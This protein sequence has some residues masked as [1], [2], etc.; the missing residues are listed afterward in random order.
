MGEQMSDPSARKVNQTASRGIV[1]ILLLAAGLRI[2]GIWQSYP[3]S[4]Y[5]DEVH[6]VERALSFGSFDFNPHWFHK[7]AFFMYLLSV[8]YGIYF[9]VGKIAGAWQS[10]SGFAT[11]YILNPGPFF[12]LGRGLTAVFSLAT[13][14]M[15]YKLARKHFDYEVGLLSALLLTLSY[16]HVVSSQHVKADSPTTF[17]TVASMYFLLNFLTTRLDRDVLVASAIAGMGA[18]TKYYSLI[19]LAPIWI[20][21]AVVVMGDTDS[22]LRRLRRFTP[23]VVAATLS[24]WLAYFV[25]SPFNFLDPLGR[26]T[27]F[28]W[29]RRLSRSFNRVVEGGGGEGAGKGGGGLF[30]WLAESV[31][32]ARVLLSTVGLGPVIG[33]LGLAGLVFLALKVNRRNAVFLVFPIAFSAGS[34]YIMSLH[35]VRHQLPLYPFLA[36]GGGALLASLA[37][38]AKRRGLVYAVLALTLVQPL[39]SITQ[40]GIR[41]S[42]ADTRNLAK[43]WI[44]ANIP[45]G[46]KLVVDE[47]GPPLVRAAE[48]IRQELERAS[49][50][51]EKGQFT[52]HYDT[53]LNYQIL[54]ARQSVAYDIFEVRFPW[55]RSALQNRGAQYLT[56]D[57]DRDFGNPLKPVGVDSYDAYVERGF[58]YAV[59]HSGR[60]AR[61]LRPKDSGEDAYP[62]YGEFYRELFA[63]GRLV[64]EFDPQA[65]NRPG[66]TVKILA[67]R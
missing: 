16:G 64:I 14:W 9:V 27:T 11:A 36:V 44:E 17:L 7:P 57:Y 35:E 12:L 4:Y 43:V 34:L 6:F 21:I 61:W 5:G 28:G 58:E 30:D 42:K 52:A 31:D 62:G 22:W 47:E 25:C 38:G 2:L 23:R 37:K 66:P 19:M 60:Y 46:T 1:A 59:V 54:A 8:E 13:V 41:I 67:L 65:D 53:Y 45:A 51:H 29:A 24:F 56:T 3:F 48:S 10:I 39:Y 63:R 55:W 49:R 50:A 18:A 15:V 20:G 33:T 40:R 26:K 32:F